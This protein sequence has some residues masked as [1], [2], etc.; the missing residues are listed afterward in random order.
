MN[1]NVLLKK[2]NELKIPNLSETYLFHPE[3]FDDYMK[4]ECEFDLEFQKIKL[5][6]KKLDIE[7][8]K[9]DVELEIKKMSFE[10]KKLKIN[11]AF[12]IDKLKLQKCQNCLP[13]NK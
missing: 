3:M 4:I 11:N 10:L 12:E 5:E 7:S 13:M 1:D 9:L 2:I 8:K 6:S